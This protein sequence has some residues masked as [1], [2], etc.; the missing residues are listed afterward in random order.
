[1]WRGSAIGPTT[2]VTTMAWT[3]GGWE[4]DDMKLFR[5]RG[6]RRFP[7][8]CMRAVTTARLAPYSCSMAFDPRL[9]G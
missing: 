8:T 2:L 1:M 7:W 5:G 4:L 9:Y 6:E 3:V